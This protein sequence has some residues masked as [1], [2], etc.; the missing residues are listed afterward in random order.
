VERLAANLVEDAIRHN[1]W[2]AGWIRVTTALDAAE[3]W[4][5]ISNGGPCIPQALYEQLFEPARRF[6]PERSAG[7]GGHGLDPSIVT[8]IAAAHGAKLTA[9]ARDCGGLRIDVRFATPP[10]IGRGGLAGAPKAAMSEEPVPGRVPAG[11]G[12]ER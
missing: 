7:A 11:A 10:P 3:A 2:A 5:S 9:Q 4:L 1:D 6:G 12:A 8:A